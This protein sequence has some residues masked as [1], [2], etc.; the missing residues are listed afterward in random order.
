MKAKKWMVIGSIVAVALMSAI[1]IVPLAF[2]QGPNIG[3]YL[4][5]GRAPM[6]NNAFGTNYGMDLNNTSGQWQGMGMRQQAFM[7]GRGNGQGFV[8]E[9][10]DGVC[11]NCGTGRGPGFVDEDGD[12]VC[13]NCGN[14]RG[15]G[16]GFVDEDGDGVCDN[17]V[18]E[19]GDGVCDNAGRGRGS[20][21]VDED[22]D[23]VCDNC[24]TGR[25]PG[26]V[27]EDGDGI[28]DHAGTG[29]QGVRRGRGMG[30]WTQ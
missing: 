8:D 18:D 6:M 28:C 25:G 11:D 9:D 14:G 30:R 5:P 13:D 15:R 3:N 24:G 17:F 26:F 22:G 4:M 16:S 21:F 20:G 10:G 7:Q 29:Q 27:D 19:D 23:G 2:A 12:G 1:L